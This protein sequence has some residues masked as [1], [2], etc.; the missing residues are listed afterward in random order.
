MLPNERQPSHDALPLAQLSAWLD[1]FDVPLAARLR[2]NGTLYVAHPANADVAVAHFE[3][4]R[5]D[6]QQSEG[7]W[8]FAGDRPGD[9]IPIPVL[10]A[11]LDELQDHLVARLEGDGKLHIAHP[12]AP[13]LVVAT[14]DLTVSGPC[15]PRLEQLE[16]GPALI[17]DEVTAV[18]EA[19]EY[20][21]GPTAENP[22]AER[23]PF[24]LTHIE[25]GKSVDLYGDAPP[26]EDK[27]VATRQLTAHD[28]ECGSWYIEHG[29]VLF[30]EQLVQIR[31]RYRPLPAK[32]AR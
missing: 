25:R 32:A 16:A 31:G 3:L 23:G 27:A 20:V 5:L 24:L 4:A 11:R 14:L 15:G 10:R 29:E 2:R 7:S 13:L 6:S 1:A 26:W 22:S 21:V 18:W 30:S 28:V 9:V 17:K 19:F 12:T 8:P